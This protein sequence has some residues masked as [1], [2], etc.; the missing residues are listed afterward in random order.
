MFTILQDFLKNPHDVDGT[1]NKLEKA[2]ASAYKQRSEREDGRRE[3]TSVSRA[4]SS[5]P[6]GA[7]RPRWPAAGAASLGLPLALPAAR[8]SS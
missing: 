8:R 2:A 6:S 5:P 7:L 3:R 1:A 4:P